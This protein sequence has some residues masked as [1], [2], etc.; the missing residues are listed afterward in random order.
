MASS[1]SVPIDLSSST[2]RCFKAFRRS[3]SIL[4]E[5][6]FFELIKVFLIYIF[7]FCKHFFI[8]LK[9]KILNF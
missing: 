9:N 6:V 2:A 4:V 5:K 1:K 8:K 3:A 7:N